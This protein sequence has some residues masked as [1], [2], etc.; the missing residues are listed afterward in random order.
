MSTPDWKRLLDHVQAVPERVYETWQS[1][2]GWNNRTDFGKEFGEDGYAWCV[3]FDWDMYHDLKFD[4]IVP[5]V[6]N[7]TAFSTWAQKHNM[8]SEYPSVGAW[9]N[10]NNGGH[11][12]LVVGFDADTVYT[13]GGNSIKAGAAD[14]G[15]G[16]GVFAHSTPRRSAKVGGYFAPRFL[17]GQCPPTADPHDP[18]GGKA[19][20]SY[21]W[22]P[23]VVPPP[24][25]PGR[26]YFGPGAH[27]VHVTELGKQ[28]V[29]RGYGKHYTSGP[30]PSWSDADRQNVRDFQLSRAAL[31]GDADGLPGP[32]TWT[33]LFS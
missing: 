8:W 27:N 19:V 33:L 4:V 10:L 12:E 28:L 20:A 31:A 22:A 32:L 23:P 26:E 9:V 24:V 16:N 29:K 25:F 15:Q 7:V 13:K 14:N 2:I 21:R 30:G 3:M 17:D 5:K 11:T 1:G 18:R 6:D